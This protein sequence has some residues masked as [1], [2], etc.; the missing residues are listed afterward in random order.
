M[1]QTRTA[2][3]A[4]FSFTDLGQLQTKCLY[5]ADEGP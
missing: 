2:D 4:H 3:A 5:A 1:K